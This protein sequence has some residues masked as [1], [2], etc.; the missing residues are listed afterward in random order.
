MKIMA[1]DAAKPDD[2]NLRSAFPPSTREAF[3]RDRTIPTDFQLFIFPIR[4]ARWSHNYSRFAGLAQDKSTGAIRNE[5]NNVNCTLL[6]WA[7][8]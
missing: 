3:Y 6:A 1:L 4:S 7:V 2:P 5:S 8:L